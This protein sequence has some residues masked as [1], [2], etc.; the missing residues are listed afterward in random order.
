MK[1]HKRRIPTMI[2]KK[3]SFIF[4][5]MNFIFAYT[6]EIDYFHSLV[7]QL[8]YSDIIGYKLYDFNKGNSDFSQGELFKVSKTK[9][10]ES[11]FAILG[12]GFV[13]IKSVSTGED[14]YTRS[15]FIF[16]DEKYN[17]LLMPGFELFHNDTNKTIEKIDISRS[18][19]M[20]I[21]FVDD[22]IFEIQLKLYKPTQTSKIKCDGNRYSFSE[23]QEIT[24][25]SEFI[26][27]F[28]EMSNVDRMGV[29][30][31]LQNVLLKLVE[32]K[33]ISQEVY[34]YDLL[35]CEELFYIYLRYLEEEL[36]ISF[37]EQTINNQELIYAKEI[38]Q[39]LT[40]E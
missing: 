29:L 11:V 26:Q 37:P 22:E 6:Q 21:F 24:N 9:K 14:Y 39:R 10:L 12:D 3:L 17:L 19:I 2:K 7:D 5:F 4:I 30:I 40:L 34:Q 36:L 18:G 25:Q 15:G 33:M 35:L 23:V 31:E 27:G 20:R 8:K 28:L 16:F 32:K 38:L 13:K 1:K